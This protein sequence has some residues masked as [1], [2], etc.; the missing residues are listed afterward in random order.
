MIK[1]WIDAM[2][3][4]TLPLA[5][6]GII[7]GSAVAKWEGTFN[8]HILVWA[9]ITAILLQI[10]SNFANDYGDFL[11]GTD[12]AKRLGDARALQKGAITPSQMK[13]A[14]YITSLLCLLSGWN[15]LHIAFEPGLYFWLFFT[16]GILAIAAAIKYTV[17]KSAYGYKALGDVFVFIFFGLVAVCGT[18]WLHAQNFQKLSVYPAITIGL[19]SVAVLHINNTRDMHNDQESGK[20]TIAILMGLTGSR[21]FLAT[22]LFLGFVS[23]LIYTLMIFNKW[24][25]PIWV[26]SITP[27]LYV[28][29]AVLKLKPSEQYN[30]LLKIMSLSTL[31]HSLLFTAAH[32]M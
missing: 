22:I 7:C 17:G 23:T 21:I 3:L 20:K 30:Q 4:R 8:G 14:L 26:F 29:I 2:R 19:Y 9:L 16:V 24:Y 25:Q 28:C 32:W 13:I 1:H 15:L 5:V 31:F 12:N 18:S 10:L 11:K 6:S 27:I